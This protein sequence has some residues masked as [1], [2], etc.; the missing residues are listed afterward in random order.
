MRLR[1]V[2]LV[3]SGFLIGADAPPQGPP[4]TDNSIRAAELKWAQEI[5]VDFLEAATSDQGEAAWGLLDA[6]V[7]KGMQAIRARQSYHV[8]KNL[9]S[10][11]KPDPK[12][13]STE[14]APNGKEI[15]VRGMLKCKIDADWISDA[16][17]KLRV[18]KA[19]DRWTIRFISVQER[20]KKTP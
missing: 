5:V 10:F 16:D 1:Y 7:A 4:P 2:I 18:A 11:Y 8:L 12:T 9:D 17:F 14:I 6:D 15:V 19:G 3:A 20:R 13:I